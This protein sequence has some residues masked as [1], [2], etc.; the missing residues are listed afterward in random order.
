LIG[1]G[2]GERVGF[3]SGHLPI[4]PHHGFP[5]RHHR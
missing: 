4:M 1:V 3:P 5:V 2:L